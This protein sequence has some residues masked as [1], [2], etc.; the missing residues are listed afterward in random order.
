[1]K[2]AFFRAWYAFEESVK[3]GSFGQVAKKRQITTSQVSRRIRQLEEMVGT[4]LLTRSR[5]G[6]ALTEVGAQFYERMAVTIRAFRQVEDSISSLNNVSIH[7]DAPLSMGSV[8]F[9]QLHR[10]LPSGQQN[11]IHLNPTPHPNR[12]PVGANNFSVILANRPPFDYIIAKLLGTVEYVC[13]AS[14]EYLRQVGDISRPK[15][16]AYHQVMCGPT[17][18]RNGATLQKRMR[19]FSLHD[20]TFS[21]YETNLALES[22]AVSGAGI[23]VGLPMYLAQRAIVAGDLVQVLPDWQ[24]PRVKAWLIRQ[25]Q[26]YPSQL[27]QQFEQAC[28]ALWHATVGLHS[29][30]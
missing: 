19:V 18:L 6:V 11:K 29:V 2:N 23:A 4:E 8:V 13:V 1:M 5:Q 7:L 17:F 24:L 3:E 27:A 25:Y 30:E 16:L 20:L 9:S 28:F 12:T 10:Y 14:P 26:R 21:Q 22:A 15:D